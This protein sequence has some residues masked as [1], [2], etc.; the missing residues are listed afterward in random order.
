[1]SHQPMREGDRLAGDA[2]RQRAEARLRDAYVEGRLTLDEYSDRVEAALAARTQGQLQEITRDLSDRAPRQIQ[3]AA[4]TRIYTILGEHKRSVRGIV[5]E[6][7]EIYAFMADCKVDLSAA[8]LSDDEVV[9]SVMAVMADVKVY[10]PPETR[11]I[12][13]VAAILSSTKEGRRT[14]D[15]AP[16]APIVRVRGASVMS[17]IEVRD[18]AP[19]R[20]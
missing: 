14:R 6:P 9:V 11:V 15:P 17:S 1:M 8:D 12:L 3:P 5:T 2:D 7:L 10:V 19:G 13:D 16:D 4:P 20:W 18:S